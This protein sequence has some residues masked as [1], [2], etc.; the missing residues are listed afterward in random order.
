[1]DTLKRT[2]SKIYELVPQ[3]SD[4]KIKRTIILHKRILVGRSDSCDLT[5]LNSSVSAI[6]AVIEI[7]DVGGRVYDMNS[8]EGTKVNGVSV[9]CQDLKLGDKVSFG[10]SE[11][12]FKEYKKG[13]SLPPPLD[14]L[15][16]EK[17]RSYEEMKTG[18]TLPSPPEKIKP[19]PSLPKSPPQLESSH[20]RPERAPGIDPSKIMIE[21]S[22]EGE[23]P[24]ISY[25]LAKDKGSEFSEY[26]FEDA[27]YIYPIF[28]WSIDKVAAE[29]IILHKGQIFSVDYLPTRKEVYPIKGFGKSENHV[30]FPRLE[31]RESIPFIKV[32][33]GEVVVEDSLSYKGVLISDKIKDAK[34]F[35]EKSISFPLHLAPQDILKLDKGD[36]QIF[37][38]NT[39]APPQIKP[40]PLFRRDNESRKYFAIISI[41]FLIFLGLFSNIVID[42]EIEKEKEPERLATILYKR[43][44]FTYKKPKVTTPQKKKVMPKSPSQPKVKAAPK[45]KEKKK[46]VT[47]PKPKP[48]PKPK[49]TP[50]P[51]IKRVQKP[52]RKTI[53]TQKKTKRLSKAKSKVTRK[54]PGPS[55]SRVKTRTRKKVSNQMRKARVTRKS[56]G[57][58]QAYRPTKKFAGSLSRLMAKGGSVSGV[59]TERVSGNNIGIGGGE[60]GGDTGSIQRAS[61]SNNIGS[62]EG[63]A[64]KRLDSSKGT[65]GLVDKKS[66][67]VAG[68][69]SQTVVL[70]DYDASVVAEILREHL[71][72]FR[73]CYQQELDR[74]NKFGGKIKLHFQIGASGRVKKAAVAQSALPSVVEGCVV[75]VLK[76]ITFPPPLGGGVVA[77]RQPMYF[78]ARGR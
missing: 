63:A 72:E 23:A 59:Q 58:V 60:I 5:I 14:T 39:E 11:F 52:P 49:S 69:P 44:K 56:K 43:K 13:D 1:M 71:S 12:I 26:I 10:A 20:Q 25:P 24:Y 50:K 32:W 38:R 45:L 4:K 47:K 18:A 41:L 29:V 9:I 65:E 68:I 34:D 19:S 22:K 3:S 21:D 77:I 8:E 35:K 42:K 55:K 7:S 40:A 57:H 31:K 62:L 64:S 66:V 54:K 17:R 6:H 53:K 30:E 73:Y 74:T 16:P 61:V 37:V 15:A 48:K 75:N 46:I 28:K 33:N 27:S 76:G 2:S 78:E 70:G 67:A 51:K 36:L